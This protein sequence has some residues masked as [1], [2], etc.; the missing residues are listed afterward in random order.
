MSSPL[1]TRARIA[2]ASVHT[3]TTTIINSTAPVLNSILIAAAAPTATI[4]PTNQQLHW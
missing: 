1:S 4:I 3:R 2:Y